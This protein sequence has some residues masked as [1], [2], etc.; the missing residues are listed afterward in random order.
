HGVIAGIDATADDK[1]TNTAT[2]HTGQTDDQ[3]S[4]ADQKIDYAPAVSIK[5]TVSSVD[6]NNNDGKVDAGDVIHY[7]IHVENTGDVTLT[8]V[9]VTDPLTGDPVSLPT[10]AVAGQGVSSEDLSASYTKIGRAAGREGVYVGVDARAVD[11]K[12]NTARVQTSQNG[13]ENSW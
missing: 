6:D 8:G 9:T 1:I 5:K 10:L 12:N 7:N 4:S 3:S 2:V 13:D 11:K